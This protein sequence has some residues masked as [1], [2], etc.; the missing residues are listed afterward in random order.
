MFSIQVLDGVCQSYLGSNTGIPSKLAHIIYLVIQF[1]QVVVPILLIVWGM[2]DLGKAVMAQKEDEIKKGQQT[3]VKR[4]V[5]AVLVFFVVAITKLVVGLF[6]P[7]NGAKGSGSLAACLNSIVKCNTDT[8][9]DI[10]A[11]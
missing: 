5:A 2:L 4:I 8:C 11:D 7:D 9:G 10:V 1:I 3:F 6:A